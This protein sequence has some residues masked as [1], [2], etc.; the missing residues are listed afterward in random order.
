[1]WSPPLPLGM[2]K[3]PPLLP[4]SVFVLYYECWVPPPLTLLICIVGGHGMPR[5]CHSPYLYNRWSVPSTSLICTG[6]VDS[7]TPLSFP[8]ELFCPGMHW[9]GEAT[10]G[11]V[12]NANSE[13]QTWCSDANLVTGNRHTCSSGMVE[14]WWAS[15]PLVRLESLMDC[16]RNIWRSHAPSSASVAQHSPVMSEYW[17]MCCILVQYSWTNWCALGS[18]LW[19]PHKLVMR[20]PQSLS[21]YH[22]RTCCP[23]IPGCST[24]PAWSPRQQPRSLEHTGDATRTSLVL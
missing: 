8:L 13:I 2:W 23:W 12:N 22:H 24:M 15:H 10:E 16:E 7:P 3:V 18:V 17:A 6:D 5:P 20:L 19:N 9:A 21:T 11:D 1:M 4:I 14:Q